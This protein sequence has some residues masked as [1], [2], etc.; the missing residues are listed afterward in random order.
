NMAKHATDPNMPFWKMLKMG[1]DHF[2]VTRK[3]PKVDV[4][5]KSYIFDADAGS[6]TF[7]ASAACPPYQVPEWITTAVAAK[8]AG[9]DAKMNAE[10]TALAAK[11]KKDAEEAAVA[12]A[13]AEEKRQREAER[14]AQPSLLSRIFGRDK[15][16]PA[17]P[18]LADTPPEVKKPAPLQKKK[19]AATEDSTASI[20]TPP[21]E[22]T[23][24]ADAVT[25]TPPEEK[26]V[27][28]KV[29]REFFWP[30]DTPSAADNPG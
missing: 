20:K 19:P 15:E 17:A 23:P 4:C 5:N 9:D 21:K 22:E 29:N 28:Q 6:A 10:A 12:E 24:P 18:P 30:E 11:A 13:K 16:Q 1:A 2:E 7:D 14:A 8:Q 25:E 26:P 27:G 3:P